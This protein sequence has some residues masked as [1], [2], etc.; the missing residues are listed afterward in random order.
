MGRPLP[1]LRGPESVRDAL[2]H[3]SLD[4]IGHGLWAFDDEALVGELCA[5]KLYLEFCPT[6]NLILGAVADLRRHPIVRARQLG[7]DYSVNSDDPV[8]LGCSLTSEFE[9]LEPEL[10]F[11]AADFAKI[12]EN[13]YRSR[14]GRS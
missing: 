1:L 6:S 11:V 10:G 3:G 13:A 9:L 2:Q 4:R 8:P 5:R 14:F 7:M 12:H